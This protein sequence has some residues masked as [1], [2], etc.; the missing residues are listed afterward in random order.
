[1]GLYATA[2]LRVLLSMFV[3]FFS[4][5]I[6]YTIV[7]FISDASVANCAP[8]DAGFI[9]ILGNNLYFS[10]ITFLTVGYGDCLPTGIFKII[11][12]LEGWTGVFLMS[13]FTV[14]FVRKILR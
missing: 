14:A 8:E 12:P 10:A 11:A 1:M 3:V 9:E 2:P 6:L 5:S 4:Y 13:Y 7:P